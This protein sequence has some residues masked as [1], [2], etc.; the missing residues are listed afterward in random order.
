[1]YRFINAIGFQAAWWACVAG[2]AHGFEIPALM[3]GAC[4]AGAHLLYTEHKRQDMRLA[5]WALGVGIATDSL[6]QY[7]SVMQFHGLSIWGLSPLWLWML[8]VLFALTLNT[9]LAFLKTKPLT[10]SAL[11]GFV[12]GPLTYYAGAELGAASWEGARFP[13]L[14][15]ALAWMVTLPGLVFLAR[16]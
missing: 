8:W 12:F 15:L 1:M 10:L 14:T 16:K 11:A 6:L 2:V 13:F 9:S 5:A 7:F 3:F 4:L